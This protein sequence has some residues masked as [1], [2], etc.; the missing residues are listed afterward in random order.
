ML[1]NH[2]GDELLP[3]ILPIVQQRLHDAN[4]RIR[5]S[6]AQHFCPAGWLAGW[7]LWLMWLTPF[8]GLP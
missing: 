8:W 6:G 2:F 3:I 7:R 1:S 5:E 4:W